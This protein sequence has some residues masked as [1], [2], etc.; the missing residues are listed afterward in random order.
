MLTSEGRALLR[1]VPHADGQT[2]AE[3]LDTALTTG[4]VG[5]QRIVV[6][7]VLSESARVSQQGQGS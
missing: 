5:L 4:H 2:L 7:E 1:H 6:D 3:R